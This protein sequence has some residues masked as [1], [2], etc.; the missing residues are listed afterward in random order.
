MRILHIDVDSLRPDH[1]GCYGYLRQTSPTIDSLAEEAVVFENCYASDVPCLPSRTALW[2]GRCRLRTGV[3]NHGGTHATPLNEGAGR[4]FRDSFITTGWMSAVRRAGVARTRPTA[5]CT[6]SA[7]HRE[8][9][10]CRSAADH[11]QPGTG[12]SGNRVTVRRRLYGA[13]PI[14]ISSAV[15]A[16]R[17]GRKTRSELSS[18]WGRPSTVAR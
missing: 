12:F 15:S 13:A 1:L 10:P 9:S 3:V 5:V 11:S 16:S 2:S 8:G 14:Q 6:P 7:G 17:S 4:W 18:A